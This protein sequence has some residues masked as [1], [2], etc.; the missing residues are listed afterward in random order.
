MQESDTPIRIFWGG[1]C[2]LGYQVG[3]A[4]SGMIYGEINLRNVA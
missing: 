1:L 3:I 2:I 4:N